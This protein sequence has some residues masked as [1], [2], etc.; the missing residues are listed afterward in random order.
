MIWPARAC[1]ISIRR[2]FVAEPTNTN[3][4][5][6]QL[7]REAAVLG[8]SREVQW[9]DLGR[10]EVPILH[11]KGT[12]MR[13]P[14]DDP[15]TP[16]IRQDLHQALGEYFRVVVFVHGGW[17]MMMS[18][19]FYCRVAL[20]LFAARSRR[21]QQKSKDRKSHRSPRSTRLLCAHSLVWKK[22]ARSHTGHGRPPSAVFPFAGKSCRR[23]VCVSG[24][25]DP[26][27]GSLLLV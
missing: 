1:F 26:V 10:E 14:F 7:S 17:M 21:T 27:S 16:R 12:A 15:S 11:L 19:V 6:V 3:L 22:R 4:P 23:C 9:H 5:S 18:S 25:F 2:E 13:Q 8:V 24:W 20:R